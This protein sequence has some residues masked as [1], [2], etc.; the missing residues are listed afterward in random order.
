MVTLIAY[1]LLA[2]TIIGYGIEHVVRWSGQD[3]TGFERAQMII[4]WPI[5]SLV[6]AVYF[7]KGLLNND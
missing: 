7:I 3:V 1:Y 2:G 5:M 6:F 4:L